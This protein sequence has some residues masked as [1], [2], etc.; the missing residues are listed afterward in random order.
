[1]AVLI[2]ISGDN[3]V[4]ALAD[5]MELARSMGGTSGEAPVS[6]PVAGQ[7]E[8]A[9]VV[10][11]TATRGRRT[12]AEEP[13]SEEKPADPPAE[14][15]KVEDP[16]A[17][18]EKTADAPALTE[19][20]VR[21]QI[22]DMLNAMQA[23]HPDDADIRTKTLKPLLEKLGAA[24]ISGIAAERYAEVPALIAAVKAE[25]GVEA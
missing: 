8:P 4:E 7:T 24:K 14:E 13:V 23:K 11:P 19:A 18:E 9:P 20:D 2:E 22:I 17:E 12:K 15:P 16:P 10:K 3:A 6:A 21:N 5:L 1:M 25:Q